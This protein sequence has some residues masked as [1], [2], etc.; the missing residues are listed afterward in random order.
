MRLTFAFKP[1]WQLLYG[2]LL[3]LEEES[4]GNEPMSYFP[5]PRLIVLKI[6]NS[7]FF[8][9][10]E[11]FNS[12]EARYFEFQVRVDANE[13]TVVFSRTATKVGSRILRYEV[14][15]YLVAFHKPIEAFGSYV[16]QLKR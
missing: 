15:P 1:A 10:L 4:A 12:I 16:Q 14:L 8:E 11:F 13:S 7:S 5:D 3:F 9:S 6:L 2:A